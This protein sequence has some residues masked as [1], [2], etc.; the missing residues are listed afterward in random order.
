VTFAAAEQARA[1]GVIG[2]GDEV[3][4]LLT[5]NGVKT[6][7]ARRFGLEP[8]AASDRDPELA[9]PIRPTLDAFEEWYAA[10]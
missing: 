6:P 7:D 9:T 10:R 5:G 8:A 3:V 2:A 4:V 1:K